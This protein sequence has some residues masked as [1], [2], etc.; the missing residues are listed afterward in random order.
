VSPFWPTDKRVGLSL[1]QV[2]L[3]VAASSGI[4]THWHWGMSA[5][6]V[7]EETRRDLAS[8]PAGRRLLLPLAAG[9]HVRGHCKTGF[10]RRHRACRY[11]AVQ[12]IGCPVSPRDVQMGPPGSGPVKPAHQA[13]LENRAGPSRH[14]SS[15]SCLSPAR[16]ARKMGRKTGYTGG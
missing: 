12:H 3:V 10:L 9:G 16:L 11:A 5:V 2:F 1:T 6:C 15:I 14:A 7:W 4:V 13:W 8:W